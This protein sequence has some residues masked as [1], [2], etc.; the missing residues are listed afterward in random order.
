MRLA[1]GEAAFEQGSAPEAVYMLRE[2]MCH[3]EYSPPTYTR[4]GGH[5]PNPNPNPNPKQV[6]P[7]LGQHHPASPP[8]SLGPRYP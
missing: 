6:G 3:V 7:L 4:P 1:Q 2:G 8:L 5:A